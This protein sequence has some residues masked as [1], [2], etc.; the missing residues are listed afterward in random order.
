MLF[1]EELRF[2]L[3]EADGRAQMYHSRCRE[4][5]VMR[6]INYGFGRHLP[7]YKD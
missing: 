1:T 3:Q 4:G 7:A 5:H 2:K 6:W